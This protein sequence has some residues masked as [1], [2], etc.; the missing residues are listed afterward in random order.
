M[1]ISY[2]SSISKRV[3][4]LPSL[5]CIGVGSRPKEQKNNSNG[6]TIRSFNFAEK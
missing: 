3:K 2:F 1:N 4:L 5:E 6:K